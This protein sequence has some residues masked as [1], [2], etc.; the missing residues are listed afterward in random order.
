MLVGIVNRVADRDIFLQEGWYR[1]P[2]ESWPRDGWRPGWVAIFETRQV[3]KDSQRILHYGRVRQVRRRTRDQLLPG[4]LHGGRAGREYYQLIVDE[5]LERESPLFLDRNRR[6]PFIFTNIRRF[7]TAAN[8]SELIIGSSLEEQLWSELRQL[9]IPAEREWLAQ[10]EGN[11]YWLDFAVFGNEGDID[12][13]VDGDR[14]HLN[15]ERA[16]YDNQRNNELTSMGW[17]VLRFTTGQVQERMG[18][19]MLHIGRTIDYVGGLKDDGLVPRRFIA[20]SSVSPQMSLFE[21][22]DVYDARPQDDKDDR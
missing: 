17:R 15:P 11:R 16:A 6:N 10:Y 9:D 5:P 20:G 14:Y 19:V 8:V 1:V 2:V 7:R 13:E 12:I 21:E 22:P 3:T 4:H 18:E